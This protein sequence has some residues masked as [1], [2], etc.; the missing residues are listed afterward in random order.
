MKHKISTRLLGLIL[1]FSTLFSIATSS[2]ELSAEY[3]SEKNKI[4]RQLSLVQSNFILVIEN[5]LWLMLEDMLQAYLDAVARLPYIAYVE[6]KPAQDGKSY[7][8]GVP[9]VS[10]Y[11][12]KIYYLSHV[13]VHA[14]YS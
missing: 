1:F 13:T 8:S 5:S 12:E 10:G 4:E 11:Q 3:R 14:I 7:T 2:Y 9:L 6:L